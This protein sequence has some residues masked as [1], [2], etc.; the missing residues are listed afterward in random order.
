[1]FEFSPETG[2][3]GMFASAFLSATLLP[4]SSEVVLIGLMTK[5]PD[6]IWTAVAVATIGN[7]CGGVTSYWLG[8]LVP[9]KAEGRAIELLKKYGI[10]SLLFSWIPIFGDALCVAAGWM[11]FNAWTSMALFA[12]GKLF[13]YVLVAGGASW[14]MATIWPTLSK[15]LGL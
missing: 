6:I 7:T 3:W 8:R 1:M 10:W 5:Y 14:F 13:R 15:M 4:G 12:V 9:N 2:L 11:R